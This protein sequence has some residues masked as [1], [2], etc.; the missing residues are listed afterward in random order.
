MTDTST[1]MACST[2]SQSNAAPTVQPAGAAE[3]SE[4]QE[5]TPEYVI[6]E[7]GVNTHWKAVEIADA[8]NAALAAERQRRERA[9]LFQRN[10]ETEANELSERLL[11]ALAAINFALG[12]G[13]L[14]LG[15]EEKLRHADLSLLHQHDAEVRKP[16]VDVLERIDSELT[17]SLPVTA[18]IKEIVHSALAQ[19][20]Q[21]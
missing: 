16:L 12:W 13:D 9:E 4:Q 5:W 8:H 17:G 1:T 10:D 20:K 14:P 11:S 19:C 15:V 7:L 6:M 21:P 3:R 2:P 18:L